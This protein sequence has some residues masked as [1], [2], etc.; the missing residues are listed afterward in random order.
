MNCYNRLI[1]PLHHLIFKTN[2]C[3]F[4]LIFLNILIFIIENCVSRFKNVTIK[5]ILLNDKQI[6]HLRLFYELMFFIF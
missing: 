6:Q 1:E 5:I 2:Y 4:W 3:N